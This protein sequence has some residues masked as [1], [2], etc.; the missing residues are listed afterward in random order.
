MSDESD[1]TS[2]YLG[3]DHSPLLYEE[4]IHLSNMNHSRYTCRTC[5]KEF[6]DGTPNQKYCWEHSRYAKYAGQG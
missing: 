5:H 1:R 2:R 4:P 3:Y 6:T